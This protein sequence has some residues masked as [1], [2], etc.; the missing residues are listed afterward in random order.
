MLNPKMTI[1]EKI[2]LVSEKTINIIN[3][4]KKLNEEE[5]KSMIQEL[6]N[7]IIEPKKENVSRL[8]DISAYLDDKTS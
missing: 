3:Y 8:M 2:I 5:K 4:I 7:M 1:E 6:E